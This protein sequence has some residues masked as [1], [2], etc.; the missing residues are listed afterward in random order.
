MSGGTELMKIDSAYAIWISK[1]RGASNA[2]VS[3]A[4]EAFD[5]GWK[6]RCEWQPMATAPK[7]G[8]AFLAHGVHDTDNGV[9]WKIG[10]KWCA[11]IQFD[12][13]R[14]KEAVISEGG[15]TL[16]EVHDFVFAKDGAPLWSKPLG[17]L[18]LPALP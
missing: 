6:A 1:T 16:S 2:S 8:F 9:H 4:F 17:W 7:D 13:W 12:I 11:M 5:A 14:A 15:Q 3:L 18:P 10:D